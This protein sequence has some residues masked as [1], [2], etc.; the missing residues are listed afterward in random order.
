[1]LNKIILMG[2][3]TRDPE[4][5]YTQQGTPVAAFTLA[6]DRDSKD[7]NGERGVDFID[8]VAWKGTAEL[9]SKYFAKGRMAVVVGRLQLRD[10]TDRD[11]NKR[12]A[13]EVKVDQV[14]FGESKKADQPAP[15]YAPPAYGAPS[16]AGYDA[17]PGQFTEVDDDSELPF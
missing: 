4:L 3:L 15:G 5:R 8:C 6:V 12:R 11:G 2:R 7:Q 13:A 10:W 17:Q 9:I 1:M 16:G 14:Y